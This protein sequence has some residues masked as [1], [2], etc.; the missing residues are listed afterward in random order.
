MKW[1][2]D[3]TD[4]ADALDLLHEIMSTQDLTAEARKDVFDLI[5]R[6]AA[7][8][9]PTTVDLTECHFSNDATQA[10]TACLEDLSERIRALEEK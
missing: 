3:S 8:P 2:S 7:A 10:L 1:L 4:L 6:F 5:E 9:E